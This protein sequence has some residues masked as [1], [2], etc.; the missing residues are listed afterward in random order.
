MDTANALWFMFHNNMLVVRCNRD[1]TY[2]V[3]EGVRPP[4]QPLGPVHAVGV[5]AGRPCF[6]CAVGAS[7]GRGLSPLD[8]RSAYDA[9]GPDLYAAAGK[10]SQMLHWDSRSRYCPAC[11]TATVAAGPLAKRCPSCE[12]EMFPSIATAILALVRKEDTA[13]L[14]RGLNF[15]GKNHGL[16]AGFL[17]VGE[18]L[19]ECVHREVLEETG[20]TI[21]NLRYFG[22]QPWPYPSGLMVGF[23]ADYQSG[24][25]VLQLD[26][27]EAGAFY[28]RNSLPL[29]PHELSLARRMIDWWRTQPL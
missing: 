22:S 11:G 4:L 18:S 13:L 10:G 27:L 21:A 5:H 25:I 28:G 8:L 7:E 14:V 2:G 1:G 9:L 17:E 6:A 12:Q 3:P 19:E 15:R 29:L 26:E 24:D 23:V 20:L 16:V